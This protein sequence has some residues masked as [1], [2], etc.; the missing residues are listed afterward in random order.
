MIDLTVIHKQ[1]WSKLSKASCKVLDYVPFGSKDFPYA[2]LGGLYTNDD[3]TK[4][5]EGLSCELYIN[6]YSA[7]K[8]R[9]E[10]LGIVNEIDEIMSQ[11]MSTEEYTVYIKKGRHAITQ[12]KDKLGWTTDNNVYFHAVL[13]YEINIKKK[14]L[15]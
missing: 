14:G 6:V 3:N 11:D 5:T 7:Y 15:I 8:G 13:I 10:I 4:N 12:D 9:K 1:I 2:Y